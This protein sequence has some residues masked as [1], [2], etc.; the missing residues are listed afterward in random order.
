MN[1]ITMSVKTVSLKKTAKSNVGPVQATKR[2][3]KMGVVTALKCDECD[4]MIEIPGEAD[5]EQYAEEYDW[6][7]DKK[8]N[9]AKCDECKE[10]KNDEQED[11]ED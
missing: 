9:T 5:A 8:E 7:Y 4:N 1:A 3:I 10:E 2:R 11:E 6:E